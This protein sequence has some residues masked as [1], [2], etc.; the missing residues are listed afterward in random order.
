[1]PKLI[2]YVITLNVAYAKIL[3][4]CNFEYVCDGIEL[5]CKLPEKKYEL[6]L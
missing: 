3:K 2:E 4:K 6:L 5:D 1:L